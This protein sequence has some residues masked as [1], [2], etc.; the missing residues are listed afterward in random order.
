[1]LRAA[2]IGSHI[3]LRSSLLVEF[4]PWQIKPL[5]IIISSDFKGLSFSI[6]NQD[7]Y[8][9]QMSY[10]YDIGRSQIFLGSHIN[11]AMIHQTISSPKTIATIFRKL[12]SRSRSFIHSNNLANRESTHSRSDQSGVSFPPIVISRFTVNMII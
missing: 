7:N 4:G 8:K 6:V 11:H 9:L 5:C 12:H 10:I 2:T 1:M 3:T